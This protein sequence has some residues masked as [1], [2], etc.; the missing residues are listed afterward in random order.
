MENGIPAHDHVSGFD[1][2]RHGFVR[3]KSYQPPGFAVFEYDNHPRETTGEHDF[4]RLNIYL[5]QDGDYVTVWNG[6]LDD[7][8]VH[9]LF[10]EL[11]LPLV[12]YTETLF[13]GYIDSDDQARIILRALRCDKALPQ[14][15]RRD[16]EHG[17]VCDRV[18]R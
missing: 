17:I 1:P 12:D 3:L 10:D 14:V 7:G 2:T 18:E 13:R 8:L 11:G 5:S 16:P 9:A 4:H 15:I 6:L